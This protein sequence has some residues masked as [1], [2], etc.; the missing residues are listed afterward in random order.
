MDGPLD[1]GLS[2]LWT[3][4]PL[5]HVLSFLNFRG[6]RIKSQNFEDLF[7]QKLFIKGAKALSESA[8]N[9]ASKNCSKW[10]PDDEITY[11]ADVVLIDVRV[12][13]SVR[14]CVFMY[15]GLCVCVCV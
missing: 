14:V 3:L 15:V 2:Y 9:H 4:L 13:V 11:W 8:K 10:D 1:S 12:C 7:Y 6:S 5:E